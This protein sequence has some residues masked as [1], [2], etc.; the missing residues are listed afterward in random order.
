M[1]DHHNHWKRACCLGAY[2]FLLANTA[3]ASGAMGAGAMGGLFVIV[4]APFVFLPGLL[5]SVIWKF[6]ATPL[7]LQLSLVG[8]LLNVLL[9]LGLFVQYL[10]PES[11]E[12]MLAMGGPALLITILS[13]FAY[14][15]ARAKVLP[16]S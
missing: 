9:F 15:N 3:F 4:V 7:T 11:I 13:G 5:L 1:F 6:R 2:V 12:N 14:N 8:F 10:L 16:T